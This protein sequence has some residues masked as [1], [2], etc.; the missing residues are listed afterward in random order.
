MSTQIKVRQASRVSQ[1]NENSPD[2]NTKQ[3]ID[4]TSNITADYYSEWTIGNNLS[5]KPSTERI[6]GLAKLPSDKGFEP[7]NLTKKN[8]SAH[9]NADTNASTSYNEIYNRAELCIYH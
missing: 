4:I 2:S 9:R 5:E 7:R 8:R 6:G 1:A 3:P